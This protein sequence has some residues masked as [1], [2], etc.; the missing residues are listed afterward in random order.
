MVFQMSELEPIFGLILLLI[1]F[2]VGYY[3]SD[4]GLT[5]REFKTIAKKILNKINR[6]APNS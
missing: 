2:H 4:K 1:G 6:K 3:E 5:L